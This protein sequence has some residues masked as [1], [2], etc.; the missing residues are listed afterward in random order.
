MTLSLTQLVRIL[1]RY[2]KAC[3]ANHGRCAIVHVLAT[4]PRKQSGHYRAEAEAR[5]DAEQQAQELRALREAARDLKR[6][7]THRGAEKNR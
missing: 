1:L 6:Q 2:T 7:T 4:K 3:C 5:A